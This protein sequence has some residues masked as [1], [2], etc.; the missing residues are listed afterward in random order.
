VAV[1]GRHS[2][3]A[4]GEAETVCRRSRQVSGSFQMIRVTG[5]EGSVAKAQLMVYA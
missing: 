3:V 5:E 2:S 4:V 1:G